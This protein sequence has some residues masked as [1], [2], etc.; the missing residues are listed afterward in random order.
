MFCFFCSLCLRVQVDYSVACSCDSI[1]KFGLI[2][3]PPLLLQTSSEKDNER[4]RQQLKSQTE[5]SNEVRDLGLSWLCCVHLI[6]V[7]DC[8]CS[9][10]SSI[11][12]VDLHRKTLKRWYFIFSCAFCFCRFFAICVWFWFDRQCSGS[13]PLSSTN[14]NSKFK[15]Q[16]SIRFWF[17]C[18]RCVLSLLDWL[19]RWVLCIVIHFRTR[20]RRF[21]KNCNN[22]ASCDLT[23][24]TLT[25]LFCCSLR[26]QSFAIGEST[27]GV[28]AAAAERA[29][30][31]N[32]Q[33]S[34]ANG[35][36]FEFLVAYLWTFLRCSF[37]FSLFSFL[38]LLV[39]RIAK[40]T[41]CRKAVRRAPRGRSGYSIT[42]LV[43]LLPNCRLR[44]Y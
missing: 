44:C 29:S 12:R 40:K 6:C 9:E 25:L 8:S 3:M 1:C 15:K 28:W 33:P 24:W 42:F 17:R 5:N 35:C 16:K 7:C 11:S 27:A 2:R 21:E 23:A 26:I 32:E 38:L 31:P 4:L 34:K 43:V 18:L 41:S 30:S 13:T 20:W 19:C 37:S 39:S 14:S 22:N 36:L 10:K